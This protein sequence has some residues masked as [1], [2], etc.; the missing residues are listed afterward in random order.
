MWI[1]ISIEEK[2]TTEAVGLGCGIFYIIISEVYK[3]KWVLCFEKDMTQ[4]KHVDTLSW[5][6]F[7]YMD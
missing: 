3:F 4:P 7:G 6:P 5:F 1:I 2:I